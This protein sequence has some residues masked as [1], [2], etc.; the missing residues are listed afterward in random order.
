MNWQ[1]AAHAVS[2]GTVAGGREYSGNMPRRSAVQCQKRWMSL[3][4][5]EVQILPSPQP[6]VAYADQKSNPVGNSMTLASREIPLF[7]GKVAGHM[8]ESLV[9][10]DSSSI[11]HMTQEPSQSGGFHWIGRSK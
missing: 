11:N 2:S 6:M 1:L 3:K 10:D 9:Y 4:T 8:E 7:L 5:N